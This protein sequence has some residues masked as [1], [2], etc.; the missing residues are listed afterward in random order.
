MTSSATDPACAETRIP[1]TAATAR[2]PHNCFMAAAP[3]CRR[4]TTYWLD[5]GASTT[6]SGC[7]PRPVEDDH[8]R[9]RGEQHGVAGRVALVDGVGEG[10][11][12]AAHTGVVRGAVL[13]AGR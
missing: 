6:C 8:V 12:R 9:V 11:D 3:F 4:I 13:R 7:R 10:G 2:T 5:V 1:A